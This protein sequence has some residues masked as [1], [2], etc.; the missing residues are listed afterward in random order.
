MKNKVK[1]LSVMLSTSI[2]GAINLKPVHAIGFNEGKAKSDVKAFL[3]PFSNWIMFLATAV[4]GI[5]ILV[6]YV[7]WNA[8]DEEEKLAQP[9]K[10]TA[11]NHLVA[12]IIAMLFG[13][14][15]K[16]FSF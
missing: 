13:I 3:D 8:K 9:F 14:V 7:G 4:V 5:S 10:K 11:K 16:W 12:Y 1:Y 6:A 2:V 15:V